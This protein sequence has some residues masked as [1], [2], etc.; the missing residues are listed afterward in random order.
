MNIYLLQFFS[1]TDMVCIIPSVVP[2]GLGFLF[3]IIITL[4]TTKPLKIEELADVWRET[5]F[6]D[7]QLTPWAE[8]YSR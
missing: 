8:L 6:I 5:Q 1:G 7:S 3:P 2:I 4:F